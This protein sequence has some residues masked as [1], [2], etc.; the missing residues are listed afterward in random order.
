MGDAKKCDRCGDFFEPH[1]SNDFEISI[2]GRFPRNV[3]LY[4]C[5]YNRVENWDICPACAYEFV[6]W[7][8]KFKE[9]DNDRNVSG[10]SVARDEED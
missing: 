4:D 3:A 6:K 7:I 5:N 9:D 2:N 1:I 10:P 8:R